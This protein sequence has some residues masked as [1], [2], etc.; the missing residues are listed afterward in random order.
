MIVVGNQPLFGL[1]ADDVKL[2]T[3]SAAISPYAAQMPSEAPRIMT[4]PAPQPYPDLM[5]DLPVDPYAEYL[6][7]EDPYE[8]AA[9]A[10]VEKKCKWWCW[11][12]IAGGVATVGGLA[13]YVAKR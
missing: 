3:R 13:Y 10:P 11:V 5:T 12:L 1:S 7:P 4:A 9:P 8:Y 6:P 2:S